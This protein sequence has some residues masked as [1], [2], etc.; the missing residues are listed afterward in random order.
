MPNWDYSPRSGEKASVIINNTPE[1]FKKNIENCFARIKNYNDQE[2]IIF[3]KAWN[4]WG[5]GNYLEPD[6]EFGFG[7]LRK[8]K[9]F[10]NL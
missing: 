10:Q 5:E 6:G 1:L 3:I 4:E 9:D 2:R 7:Y 8:I